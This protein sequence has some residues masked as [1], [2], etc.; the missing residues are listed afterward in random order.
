MSTATKSPLW[1]IIVGVIALLW[2]LIGLW[3][4]SNSISMT[5]EQLGEVPERMRGY[6]EEGFP[7]F[8]WAAY[9]LAVIA[10]VLGSIML[11]LKK[12][13]ATLIFS[14]SLIG[15]LALNTWTFLISDMPESMIAEDYIIQ[16][17]VIAVGILLLFLSKR[18][19]REGWIG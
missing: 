4:F 3:G 19:E 14:L 12:K 10:G 6:F 18:A 5:P 9:G 2:N 1:F 15:V 7:W 16:T 8:Y 11:L 13:W 17:S